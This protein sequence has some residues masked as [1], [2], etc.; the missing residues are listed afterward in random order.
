MKKMILSLVILIVISGCSL[1]K[2]ESK[3]NITV[4]TTMISDLVLTIGGERV[5]VHS[6][7]KEGVD[8]HSYKAR[9]S[10]VLAIEQAD[11][12]AYNGIY[13][14]AKIADIFDS[15][16][17]QGKTLMKIEDGIDPTMLLEAEE[18]VFDPHIWFDV[19]LWRQAAIY[20]EGILSNYEPLSKDSF[21][22][23]LDAY[24]LSL[25]ALEE[26]IINEIQNIPA[27]Q[28][29]LVTAHDAFS[30]LGH[31]YGLEVIG[32]QGINSQSE[33]GIKDINGLSDLII[34]RNIKSV[35]SESSVPIKTVEALAASVVSRGH[36]LSVGGE[37]YS[38][39]LKEN[40][41]YVETFK[42]NIDTIVKGLK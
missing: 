16:D 3:I 37:L 17:E 23:N 13:L 32:V 28:R 29:V 42:L 38:D 30:Y 1:P 36:Q 10:D 6:M 24:L 33:A 7:M 12:V 31:A 25:D 20:V 8:P 21:K 19:A 35:Y 18:G 27:E 22:T 41:S 26:Y 40:T 5:A 11:I 9:P 14:E 2:D 15:L 4:T 39:S 34:S